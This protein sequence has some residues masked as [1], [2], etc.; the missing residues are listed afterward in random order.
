M[1][2][3]ALL[4]LLT[5]ASAIPLKEREEKN[6]VPG[7]YIVKFKEDIHTSAV[8]DIRSMVSASLDHEYSFPGF[9]GFASTLSEEEFARLLKS[10]FVSHLFNCIPLRRSSIPHGAFPA[11]PTTN[12]Q[13][14]H[15]HTHSTKQPDKEHAPTSSTPASKSTTPN[16]K[17][18]PEF[19]VDTSGEDKLI[20]GYGHGTHVAGTIGSA[21]YG[22]AKKTQL[23]AVKV[24]RTNGYGTTAGVIAGINFVYNDAKTRRAQCAKGIV[25]NMSLGGV[26]N[27]AINEA[28]AALVS[29]GVFLAVAAGN[30][31][32]PASYSSPASEPSVCT[33]GAT[34]MNDRMPEWSNWGELVDVLAPGENVTSTWVG[35]G[36]RKVSGTSMA[37]PH[38]VGLAAYLLGLG[39]HTEAGLC[40]V[41]RD[42]ATQEVVELG[43]WQTGTPNLLVWN[44]V[45]EGVRRKRF[46][47]ARTV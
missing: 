42:M 32:Y 31:G 37:T 2:A 26:K 20:D 14:A 29:S 23:F 12:A 6:L 8:Q 5:A 38:V 10:D 45:E 36:M 15:P 30:E 34:D 43:A 16:S 22:V 21:T 18:V 40:G 9:L 19:L 28:A 3:I 27:K 47:G 39:G 4:T 44:G 46:G 41:I 35:G 7:K 25:S 24:L 1:L 11:Y 33:V 13:T 17:D